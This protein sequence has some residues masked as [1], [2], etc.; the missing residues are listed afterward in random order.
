M[1]ARPLPPTLYALTPGNLAPADGERLVGAVGRA[2]CAGLRGVLLREPGLLDRAL[3]ELARELARAVRD[4]GGYLGLHDRAH[5]ARAVGADALHL[6]FRSLAPGDARAALGRDGALGLSTHAAD[7]PDAGAAVDYVFF[8]PVRETPGKP[9]W[10]PVQGFEGL[11]ARAAAS[12]AP[13]WALGG[14]RPEDAPEAL[15]AGARGIAVLGGVLGSPDPARAVERYL[16][17]LGG[18]G[19]G[20]AELGA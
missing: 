2:L 5:V 10:V 8:G 6:G 18:A 19:L 16:A 15:A 4:V 12:S 14:L 17:A 7:P 1:T 20:G 9:A 11:A 3:F 13:V